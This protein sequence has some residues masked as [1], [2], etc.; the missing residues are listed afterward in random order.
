MTSAAANSVSD[1]V[2]FVLG[3]T[4]SGK[5][6]VGIALSQ[7]LDCQL[8]SV[9]S[10][11]V[12]RGMDIGTAKPSRQEQALAPHR[13]IDIREPWETYSAAD[14]CADARAE[15]SLARQ[16]RKIPVLIGGTMLYFNALEH[17][18]ADMPAASQEVRDALQAKAEDIGWQAMHKQLAKVDSVTA[19]RVHPN[20]PQRIQ[21]ALEVWE[22]S[23]KSL[24]QWH[25][26]AA[27]SKLDAPLIK[28]G[29]FPCDRTQL[30]E[31]ISERFDQMLE[32]GFLQEVNE[33]RAMNLVHA[34]LPSMRSVG[35]RQAWRHLD[36]HIDH[37]AFREQALAAT[38]QLAKR[39]FTW[40]RSM[41]GLT[42]VDS[43]SESVDSIVNTLTQLLC[44][45]QP[46]R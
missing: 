5:T 21:R 25:A 20:D 19:A 43:V 23:G 31:R 39:Q 17:G 18:L 35:Y 36:G 44:S 40:M 10:S 4:A 46:S 2:V 24:S 1:V 45:K 3:P 7:R 30:H 41:Q 29:L 27:V 42:R 26:E 28:L 37:N 38:R 8:I 16:A 32:A 22:M 34:A 12:Y 9:D 11:L 15:I 33:L 13:L 14:F 6:N